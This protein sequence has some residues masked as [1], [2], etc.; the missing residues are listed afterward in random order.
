MPYRV[1]LWL[2]EDTSSKQRLLAQERFA[3]A[4]NDSLGEAQ[5]VLPTYHACAKIAQA[6]GD[7]P[8]LELLSDAERHVF[9]SWKL[10]EKAA[11]TAAFG[12]H[13]YMGEGL[14][15]LKPQP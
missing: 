14:Y 5:W 1:E 9:E 15:E 2:P 10:A 8:D 7:E 3:Q 4:L 11:L 6:Y 13:R 12:E